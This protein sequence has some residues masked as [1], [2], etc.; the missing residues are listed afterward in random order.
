M[1]NIIAQQ[2]ELCEGDILIVKNINKLCGSKTVMC[3]LEKVKK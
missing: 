1:Y 2:D 3:N